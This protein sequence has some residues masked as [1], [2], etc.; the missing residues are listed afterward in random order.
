M[1]SDNT[2]TYHILRVYAPIVF[3]DDDLTIT[4]P[5]TDAIPL[6]QSIDAYE[7]QLCN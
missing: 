5:L 1:I 6:E 3:N 4:L 7:R 2:Y